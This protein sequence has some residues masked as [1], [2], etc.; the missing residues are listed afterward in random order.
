MGKSAYGIGKGEDSG[1]GDALTPSMEDRYGSISRYIGNLGS[2]MKKRW[3]SLDGN[4]KEGIESGLLI[5]LGLA[6]YGATMLVYGP[7]DLKLVVDFLSGKVIQVKAGELYMGAFA[8]PPFLAGAIC[9]PANLA[10]WMIKKYN[11]IHGK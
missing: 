10:N 6:G 11:G 7:F 8:T 2:G 9:G 4:V 3:N 5:A 1:L